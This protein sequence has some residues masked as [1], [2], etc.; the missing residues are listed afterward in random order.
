MNNKQAHTLEP[1]NDELEPPRKKICQELSTSADECDNCRD[2]RAILRTASELAND[3]QRFMLSFP[4]STGSVGFHLANIGQRFLEPRDTSCQLCLMLI[5]SRVNSEAATVNS[6]QNCVEDDSVLRAYYFPRASG[7][8]HYTGVIENNS[9][10]LFIGRPE[11]FKGEQSEVI[12]KFI[13]AARNGIAVLSKPQEASNL[14]SPRP[15]PEYYEPKLICDWICYCQKYHKDC[16]SNSHIDRDLHLI[17][18]NSRRVELAANGDQY[19]ALS[20]VWGSYNTQLECET[21]HAGTELPVALPK[22]IEDAI[23]VTRALGYNY[24]WVDKYCI[25]QNNR[26][27][28]HDQ[29][30]Q[31]H[32][33]YEKAELTIVAACG[34]DQDSGLVGVS[35][36]RSGNETIKLGNASL[37][38]VTDPQQSIRG[39]RWFTRGWTFQEAVLARRRLVFTK[40]QTYFECNAINCCENFHIP[41]NTLHRMT[42]DEMKSVYR[43]GMFGGRLN[44]HHPSTSDLHLQY[45][46]CVEDYSRRELTYDADVLNAFLGITQRFELRRTKEDP[47]DDLEGCQGCQRDQVV[48]QGILCFPYK[49]RLLWNY[50]CHSLCWYHPKSVGAKRRPQFPSWTWLGWSGGVRFP[51]VGAQPSKHVRFG[52]PYNK[53]LTFQSQS[54]AKWT[55]PPRED[56]SQPSSSTY[57]ILY[58]EAYKVHERLITYS[59]LRASWAFHKYDAQLYLS[60]KSISSFQLLEELKDGST[61]RCIYVGIN[62]WKGDECW[63]LLLKRTSSDMWSR[64]GLFQVYC[65]NSELRLEIRKYSEDKTTV[66]RTTVFKI[67]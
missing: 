7:L 55:V 61:W 54:G 59:R 58:L 44:M 26:N 56:W 38:W 6:E 41:L 28:K 50:F 42:K 57:P 40:E 63:V 43:E 19:V 16:L 10:A 53:N 32:I 29:I 34:V 4:W 2:I 47:Q 64:A 13:S 65:G 17:D 23:S 49:K 37:S 8:V 18:C 22:V 46:A 5:R 33:I 12:L 36:P 39:S 66:F 62:G 31:M 35:T 24:L 25:D 14:F 9:F 27:T 3:L 15:I 11:F 60:E 51:A 67:S 30:R 52:P 1:T 48:I 20:Y 45:C 21:Q